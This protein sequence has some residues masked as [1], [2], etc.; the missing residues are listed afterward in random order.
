MNNTTNNNKDV[1]L[2]EFKMRVLVIE[3]NQDLAR[4]FC[5]LLE[6]MGCETEV[7][8]N[9]R[10]GLQ[11]TLKNSPDIIF[12]DLRLPG[13]KNGFDFARELRANADYAD[14]PLIA[15]TGYGDVEAQQR[16]LEAGFNRVFA[17]PIKFAEIQDVLKQYQKR[18]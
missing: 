6:V 4:L 18:A 16:A 17:K 3:D 11:S 2:P 9:V 1:V 10:A 13:E 7:A 15:V 14:L 8:F 5:D 12:C